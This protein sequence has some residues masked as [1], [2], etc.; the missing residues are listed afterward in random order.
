MPTHN[1][2]ADVPPVDDGVPERG[3]EVEITRM[4]LRGGGWIGYSDDAVFVVDDDDRVKVS[5]DAIDGLALRTLEFDIAVM[6]L[7]LIA[8]GAYVAL[9]RNPLVGVGFGAV[10]LYSAYRTYQQRHELVIDVDN[11]A[12]PISVYPAHPSECHSRLVEEVREY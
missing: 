9:T 8:V 6:S 11:E 5:K 2:R 7:L 4:D 12:K 1:D 10:G 3:G